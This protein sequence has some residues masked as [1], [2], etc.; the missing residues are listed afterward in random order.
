[1]SP[2]RIE[3]GISPIGFSLNPKLVQREPAEPRS[4]RSLRSQSLIGAEIEQWKPLR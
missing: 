1:M 2:A 4:V 3:E